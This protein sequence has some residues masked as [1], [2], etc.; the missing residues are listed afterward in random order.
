[1]KSY[2]PS[3]SKFAVRCIAFPQ[4]QPARMRCGKG[5]LLLIRA[6]MR[7]SQPARMRCGKVLRAR[8]TL[9]LPRSQP[10]RM[11]CGKAW[12][13]PLP[14]DY[15]SRNPREC[16]VAKKTGKKEL[17]RRTCRN[18][19]ECA[20]A[21]KHVAVSVALGWVATR[22]NALRQSVCPILHSL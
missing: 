1:M 9:K 11:R 22:A 18:P 5:D 10:A 7:G 8:A 16:A 13:S 3:R 20:E 21:K 2:L 14:S 19:R 17:R 15:R 6:A 4:S 12:Y